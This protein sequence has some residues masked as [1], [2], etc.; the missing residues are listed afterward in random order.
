MNDAPN[1]QAQIPS[2]RHLAPNSFGAFWTPILLL[3]LYLAFTVFMF[4]FGPVDWLVP[5]T[6]KLLLFLVVNYG[7]LWVGYW[8]GIKRDKSYIRRSNPEVG[9][10]AA[11]R[12]VMTL[13]L[14][15]MLFN[16]ASSL[17]RV[18][19]IRGD[20]G[21]VATALFFPGEA[22]REAQYVA[23]IDRDG[24]I[25]PG[26]AGFSWAFRIST[27]L[28]VFNNIYF[29]L[30]LACWRKLRP[31]YKALF[32]LSFVSTLAYT[33]GVGAKSWIGYLLFSSIPVAIYKVHIATKRSNPG[34]NRTFQMLSNLKLNTAKTQL[35]I[36]TMLCIFVGTVMFFQVD[37]TE[38]SGVEFDI[39]KTMGGTYGV[40][41]EQS[42]VPITGGRMNFGFIMTCWYIS[43]GY[44]GLA[45]CMELPFEST[46]GFGWSKALQVLLH[47]YLGGPDMFE[48]SY[49]IRNEAHNGWPALYWWSTIFPWL[50][51]DTTFFGTVLFMLLIGFFMGRCWMNVVLTGNPIGFAVLAQLFI[52]VFMFP[53]NNALAQSLDGFFSFIGVMFFY[54]V[55]YKYFKHRPAVVMSPQIQA[56]HDSVR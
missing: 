10:V 47:N 49:L 28:S 56:A 15:S 6:P 50:A 40:P 38:D 11:P 7:G 8:W 23:Q 54:A 22:Y 14:W 20:L 1:S 2:G 46:Y 35:L 4:F 33:V 18:R 5:N 39:A 24:G 19:A 45:L 52:L 26:M 53:A 36:L 51:S 55:S 30:G 42:I 25:A 9:V 16:I 27:I 21:L 31:A 34:G 3:E 17:I 43:H 13:I 32:I 44:E 12:G 48:R 37:R 29:P 41:N